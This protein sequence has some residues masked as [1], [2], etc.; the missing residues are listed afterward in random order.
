MNK[1]FIS[2]FFFKMEK[3]VNPKNI[4]VVIMD[5]DQRLYKNCYNIIIGGK[6]EK[7]I[8]N[9]DDGPWVSYCTSLRSACWNVSQH[10]NIESIYTILNGHYSRI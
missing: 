3:V 6:K 9:Q 4:N 5:S 1:L 2:L 8:Y 10:S 7:H